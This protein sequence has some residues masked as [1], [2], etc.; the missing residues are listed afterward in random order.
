MQEKENKIRNIKKYRNRRLYDVSTS[1]YVIIDDIKQIILEGESI[2]VIDTQ[3]NEDVTR[4]IL[5]QIIFEEEM[6]KTPIF[7]NNFLC[8]LIKFYGKTMQPSLGIFF[9]QGLDTFK[10]LQ[11]NFYE[12]IK[13]NNY[14]K[15]KIIPNIKL[16]KDFMDSQNKEIEKL[17]KKHIKQNTQT[18]FKMQDQIQEQAK[19]IFNYLKFPFTPEKED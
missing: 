5:L 15:D 9:E 2:K 6:N 8:Q 18:F 17:L 4:N 16:W 19:Y 7:S 14:G 11:K 1:S 3:T 10:Q 12:Q 13:E